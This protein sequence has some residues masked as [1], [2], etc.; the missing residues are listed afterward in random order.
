MDMRMSKPEAD[1]EGASTE[2]KAA[3]RDPE[4]LTGNARLVLGEYLP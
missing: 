4:A 2:R 3:A 1:T